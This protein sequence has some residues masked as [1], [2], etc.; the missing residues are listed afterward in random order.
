MTSG[1]EMLPGWR[2]TRRHMFVWMWR[3]IITRSSTTQKHALITEAFFCITATSVWISSLTQETTEGNHESC[4]VNVLKDVKILV[5]AA[6]IWLRISGEASPR[7]S[8]HLKVWRQRQL[9]SDREGRG[10]RGRRGRQMESPPALTLNYTLRV[11][12]SPKDLTGSGGNPLNTWGEPG[13]EG[14]RARKQTRCWGEEKERNHTELPTE[15][16]R[17]KEQ[18]GET[19]PGRSDEALQRSMKRASII[20]QLWIMGQHAE[21]VVEIR[22]GERRREDVLH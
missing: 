12:L 21:A 10:R 13:N 7:E 16:W 20:Q 19:E 6:V 22:G 17:M 5:Y 15:E 11:T 3:K 9:R 2:V 1:G 14:E 18:R 4:V 8:T